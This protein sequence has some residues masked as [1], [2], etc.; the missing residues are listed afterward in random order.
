MHCLGRL[1]HVGTAWLLDDTRDPRG[2]QGVQMPRVFVILGLLSSAGYPDGPAPL[3]AKGHPVPYVIIDE[4]R[5][6]E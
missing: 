1:A 2:S 5:R 6:F 4:L 3:V